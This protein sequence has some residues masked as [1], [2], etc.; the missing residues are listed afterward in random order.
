MVRLEYGN[1]GKLF[2]LFLLPQQKVSRILFAA[3]AGT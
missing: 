1:F 3:E 2:L